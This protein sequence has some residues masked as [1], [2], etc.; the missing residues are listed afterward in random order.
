MAGE[1]DEAGDPRRIDVELFIRHPTLKP[2]EITAALGI[3]PLIVRGVGEPRRAPSGKLLGGT[4]ERTAWRHSI[5]YK[6]TEQWFAEKVTLLVDLLLPHRSFLTGLRATG[7]ETEIIVQFL[8]DG[9]LGDHVPVDTL[10]KMADLQ[11]DFGIEC[12]AVPQSD[13]LHRRVH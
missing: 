6:L 8:G 1:Q 3:E 12:F 13:G 2:A 7:G 10:V 5:R 4:Y 9:Y 11:L